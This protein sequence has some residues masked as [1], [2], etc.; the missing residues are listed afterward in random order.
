MPT[1]NYGQNQPLFD[2]NQQNYDH[3]HRSNTMYVNN[4]QNNPGNPYQQ[5]RVV[6]FIKLFTA[7]FYK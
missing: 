4:G 5:N 2:F 1:G 6:T 3:P 7:L